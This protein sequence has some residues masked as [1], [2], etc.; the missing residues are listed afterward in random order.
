MSFSSIRNVLLKTPSLPTHLTSY[1]LLKAAAVLLMIIDHLGYYFFPE[2]N[3]LRVIGRFCVPMW[4]FLIGYAHSRHLGRDLLGSALVLSLSRFVFGMSIFPLNILWTIIAIRLVLDPVMKRI[5]KDEGSYRSLFWFV[6]VMI[7]VFGTPLVLVSE[8]GIQG[9]V[10]AAA[11]YLCRHKYDAQGVSKPCIFMPKDITSNLFVF[12][13]FVF[14]I[15]QIGM[16]GFKGYEIVALVAGTLVVVVALDS[17]RPREIQMRYLRFIV[18]FLQIMGRQTLWIYVG[19]TLVFRMLAAYLSPERFELWD[20][21]WG[22]PEKIVVL[23]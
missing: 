10:F 22:G 7:A 12:S 19:H 14:V 21:Q 1:D 8:Y 23:E 2:N 16:F 17:F 6:F 13:I 15:N 9:L 11:G 5:L 20:W 4:F 18:P 3:W